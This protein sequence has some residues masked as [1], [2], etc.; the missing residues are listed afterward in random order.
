MLC[1]FLH[2]RRWDILG[3]ETS[4]ELKLL[5]DESL[6]LLSL[7]TLGRRAGEP[8]YLFLFFCLCSS[9]SLCSTASLMYISLSF[10]KSAGFIKVRKH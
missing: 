8:S 7:G 3:L 10:W 5:A 4:G 2:V 9:I 1:S 6:H